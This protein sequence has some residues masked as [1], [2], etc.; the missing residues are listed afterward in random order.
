MQGHPKQ[1]HCHGSYQLSSTGTNVVH[2]QDI[3]ELPSNLHPC[4]LLPHAPSSPALRSTGKSRLQGVEQLK[5]HE[6]NK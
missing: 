5:E 6:V 4:S 2:L 1:R 3:P